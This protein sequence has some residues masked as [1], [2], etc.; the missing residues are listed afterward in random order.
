MPSENL[1]ATLQRLQHEYA[2]SL[3]SIWT[4][5]QTCW[6]T[7]QTEHRTDQLKVL[8]GHSHKMAGSAGTFGFEDL[9]QQARKLDVLFYELVQRN[10]YPSTL[11]CANING[12]FSAIDAIIEKIRID[13]NPD[14]NE[15]TADKP[16]ATAAE[17]QASAQPVPATKQ[18]SAEQASQA[19]TSPTP[20]PAR[21]AQQPS[22]T[23][24]SEHT[25]SLIY[26]LDDDKDLS[27]YVSAH[28][29]DA[30]YQIKVFNKV[31][32][33]KQYVMQHPPDLLL[34]DVVLTEDDL[35]GPKI[36]FSIQRNREEPLPVIFMSSRNDM[37]ARLAAVRA[38]G[39]AYFR[40]PLDMPSLLAK[41]KQ[42][43][44]Q[45]EKSA[46]R[47][48]IVD[49]K[50]DYG[51]SYQQALQASG[52]HTTLLQ[53]PMHLIERLEK[54]KPNAIL[55]N[56]QLHGFTGLEMAL[57]VRQQAAY[58]HLPI[59]FFGLQSGQMLRRAA[60]G[61]IGDDFINTQTSDQQMVNVIIQRIQ[62][63]KQQHIAL[64]IAAPPVAVQ[65]A[66]AKTSIDRLTEVFDRKYFMAQADS[67]MHC[68]NAQN[69]GGLLYISLDNYQGIDHIMGLEAAE[70][71]LIEAADFLKTQIKHP[72][73]LARYSSGVFVIISTRHSVHA[74]QALANLICIT[75]EKHEINV[76]EQKVIATCSIGLSLAQAKTDIK[77]LLEEAYQI[78]QQAQEEG[79]NRVCLHNSVSHSKQDQ[80]Q[81][82]YWQETL[83]NA[84]KQDQFYLI[85][86]P[87]TS[88]HGQTQ[89]Y[90]DVL[91]R[92]KSHENEQEIMP[93]VFLPI[94]KQ[95]DMMSAVDRWVLKQSI[96][97]L[98]KERKQQR[99][100][101]FFVRIS[102]DSLGDKKLLTWLRKT[103]QIIKVPPDSLVF[104]IT[105]EDAVQ[106]FKQ[107]QYFVEYVR[108]LGCQLCLRDFDGSGQSIQLLNNL[109][110]TFVK[111]L[112]RLIQ[113]LETKPE[114][115][116]QIGEIVEKV[117]EQNTQVIA[118]FVEDINSLNQLWQYKVD[119]IAGYFVESPETSLDYDFE[120]TQV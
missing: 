36:I 17:T 71:L 116:E 101:Y 64:P 24:A 111:I 34:M 39:H 57:I 30:G 60:M 98:A 75:L 28:L 26:M 6:L 63:S 120:G 9:S 35:A 56:T 78:C 49:D 108:K 20:E 25:G 90:Y 58:M 7:I 99:K 72:D 103:L 2:L 38:N 21:K 4:E 83:E 42:L 119:Y 45:A 44:K 65:P 109:P 106:Q 18:A 112:G 14:M 32:G 87:I 88:L 29:R 46:A 31:S 85:Y 92:L 5:M 97:N 102:G 1:Q 48:L 117:H 61:G 86:Q 23:V 53:Q 10:A 33:F 43:T 54:I 107:C 41:V 118:P 3:P 96:K 27:A 115:V 91:L 67:V 80:Q 84:V 40:K 94:A 68:P 8:R 69:R 11:E 66:T 95:Q 47:I 52:M 50:S 105:Q 37:T 113:Q 74:L 13:K 59:I 19:K 15:D 79:G 22:K 12:R 51:I 100:L 70:R 114:V 76:D 89:A 93:S 104:D 77:Q 62:K 110:F 73:I 81:K 16:D 55:I 82:L